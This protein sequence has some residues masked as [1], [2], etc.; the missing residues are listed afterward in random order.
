VFHSYLSTR[1]YIVD[2][3]LVLSVL[4]DGANADV[5]QWAQDMLCAVRQL[6]QQQLSI[7]LKPVLELASEYL[8]HLLIAGLS[9]I[10]KFTYDLSY[11][12][13]KQFAIRVAKRHPRYRHAPPQT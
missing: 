13:I 2:G 9:Y 8:T 3:A 11:C 4:S 6:N 10:M 12:V 7:E 1:T 5:H